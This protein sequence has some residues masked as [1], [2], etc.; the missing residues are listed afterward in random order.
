MAD[1]TF[2]KDPDAV[3]DYSVNWEAWL[4]GDTI[5][6]SE[7]TIPTGLTNDSDSFGDSVAT[8]WLSSGTAGKTY[9]IINHITTAAGRQDDNSSEQTQYQD[10]SGPARC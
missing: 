8:V 2:I 9:S 7:W 6:A 1:N 10:R 4:S 5:S 3:L